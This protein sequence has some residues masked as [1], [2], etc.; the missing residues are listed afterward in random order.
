MISIVVVSHSP[1]LAQAATDL[2]LQMGG[3]TPPR[4][5]V[6]AGTAAGDIGTDPV[7]IAQA[8]DESATED[9]VLVIMDLGSA[10]LS[11]EMASEFTS[12]PHPVRL[13]PAPFVEGLVTAVVQ[14][15]GG[16]SLDSV[17][18]EVVRALDPKIAQLAT[19]DDAP[20]DETAAPEASTSPAVSTE[21]TE[22]ATDT[23]VEVAI[24]DPAGLHARPASAIVQLARSFDADV[25]VGLVGS[26]RPAVD[27]RSVIGLMSLGAA[28]G[29]ILRI[30]A[31]GTQASEAR[32]TIASYVR[33]NSGN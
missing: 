30:S 27:A 2:A 6:A 13:S 24:A 8:I 10:V 33:D 17:A 11:A 25:R 12:T 15:A 14:A 32:E 19:A 31:T 22:G 3:A 4:V 1:A 16:A 9:G 7:L 5:V 21:A 20:A 26:E 28:P 29:A 18:A 23:A